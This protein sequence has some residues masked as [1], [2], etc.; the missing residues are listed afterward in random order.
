MS[1][2]GKKPIEIPQGV[3]VEQKGKT[4]KA[5]G[6]L[7]TL[8]VDCHPLIDVKVDAGAG[9]IVVTNPDIADRERRALHGT[10]RALLNNLVLGVSKG[11]KRRMQIFGTGYNLKEQGGKLVLQVGYCHPV[12]MK[13]PQGVK[14]DIKVP[15]TR[16]NDVPASFVLASPDKQQL[17]QFAAE[18]RKVRPPEPYKGKGIRYADEVV[19]RKVGKAFASGA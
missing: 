19:R 10:T 12:E 6:P 17:G 4:V 3:K 7:G 9:R 18:I 1:R 13:I 15:A 11:F 5:T 2:I 8:Q 14:V 16:G